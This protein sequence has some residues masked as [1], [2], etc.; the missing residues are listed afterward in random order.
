MKRDNGKDKVLQALAK[1]PIVQIACNEAGISRA[2]Y[3]RWRKEDPA[4]AKQADTELADGVQ[5]MNDIAES[6]LLKAVK[7]QNLG[8]IVFWLKHRHP[9]YAEKLEISATL[10]QKRVLSPEQ[11]EAIRRALRLASFTKSK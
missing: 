1:L 2:S 5:F 11:E 9:A 3:Y 6:Q 4:F 10:R 7:E 8:A